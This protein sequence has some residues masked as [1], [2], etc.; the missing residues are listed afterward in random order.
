[1]LAHKAEDE[2]EFSA[3]YFLKV[4]HAC[5]KWFE[6]RCLFLISPAGSYIGP[7]NKSK[8]DLHAP[9]NG[10]DLVQSGKENE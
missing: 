1:M 9:I 2:G 5:G 6:P 7:K 8:A 10:T 3:N 4:M